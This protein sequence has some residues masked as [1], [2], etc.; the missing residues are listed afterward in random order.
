[1]HKE[2]FT[3]CLRFNAKEYVH[4]ENI[5]YMETEEGF[6]LFISSQNMSSHS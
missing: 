2:Y 6:E 4:N 5:H 3:P 1:M